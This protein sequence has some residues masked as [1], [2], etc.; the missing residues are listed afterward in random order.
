M[1]PP[2]PFLFFVTMDVTFFEFILL[3][4][5]SLPLPEERSLS[6]CLPPF[7][8]LTTLVRPYVFDIPLG[9]GKDL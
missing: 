3:F 6:M 8:P 7:L 1:L 4:F 2:N 5:F 9:N